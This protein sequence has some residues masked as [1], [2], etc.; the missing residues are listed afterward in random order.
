MFRAF[1]FYFCIRYFTV[2]NT[3]LVHC[4][5]TPRCCR[6]AV[7]RRYFGFLSRNV[8]KPR[9]CAGTPRADVRADVRADGRDAGRE[10]GRI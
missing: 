3:V 7:A 8:S 10:D 5:Q 4:F 6:P 1:I 2:R 9:G